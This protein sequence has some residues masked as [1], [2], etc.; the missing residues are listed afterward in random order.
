MRYKGMMV[1]TRELQNIRKLCQEAF[2]SPSS[3]ESSRAALKSIANTLLLHSRARQTFVD[4][5][6][7]GRV[8]DRLK[9]LINQSYS[10]QNIE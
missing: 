2:D 4:L 9:V 10:R 7:A 5:G 8:A 6:Y 1:L 3:P